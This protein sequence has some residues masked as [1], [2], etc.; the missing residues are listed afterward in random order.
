MQSMKNLLNLSENHL[1]KD[2]LK[3][4]NDI[5]LIDINYNK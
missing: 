2:Q 5:F 1:I 4:R 3:K